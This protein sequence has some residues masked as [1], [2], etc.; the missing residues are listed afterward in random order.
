MCY[1]YV[2]IIDVV[3]KLDKLERANK[4]FFAK[5]VSNTLDGRPSYRES[6]YRLSYL[7]A[8]VFIICPNTTVRLF[9]NDKTI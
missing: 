1:K 3:N 9:L 2:S 8:D 4:L 5:H 6:L 7:I